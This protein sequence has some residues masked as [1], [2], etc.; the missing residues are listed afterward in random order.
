MSGILSALA[1]AKATILHTFRFIRAAYSRQNQFAFMTYSLKA[2]SSCSLH[3]NN[4]YSDT[5]ETH[6]DYL[7]LR[8]L[9]FG[10]VQL[11]SRSFKFFVCLDSSFRHTKKNIIK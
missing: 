3:V 6:K 7:S 8:I 11:Q 1:Y 5:S 2:I 9:P 4:A 10:T